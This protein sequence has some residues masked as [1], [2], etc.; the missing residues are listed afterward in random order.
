MRLVVIGSGVIGTGISRLLSRKEINS[1]LVSGRAFLENPNEFKSILE[2]CDLIIECLPENYEIKSAFLKACARLDYRNL[3][4]TCTS[5]LSINSLQL[6]SPNPKNF[7]GIHF[8]NPPT[9]I[10]TVE[11]ISGELTSEPCKRR[12]IDLINEIGSNPIEIPDIPGFL[13]N[14]ILFSMLNQ[15]AKVAETTG[16][17]PERIDETI[18]NVCGHK[19]GPLATLDMIGLDVS[20]KIIENLH[21]S[22]PET[23]SSPAQI[24]MDKVEAGRLGRKSGVGFFYYK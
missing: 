23:F 24:L 9:L 21:F 14:S 10:K 6:L 13:V 4:G 12:A 20:L 19:L 15:A 1:H 11:I 7:L 5:S 2:N 22:S 17:E 16:L 18:R 8:M 3:I